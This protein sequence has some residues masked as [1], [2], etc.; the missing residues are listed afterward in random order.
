M[1]Q[2]ATA[3]YQETLAS[4]N[5][6]YAAATAFFV[7]HAGYS[8]DPNVETAEEGKARTAETLA[9]AEAWAVEFDVTFTWEPDWSVGDH[10]AEF[11]EAYT[12][13]PDTCEVCCAWWGGEVIASLGCIDDASDAYR[14]VIEAELAAEVSV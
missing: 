6:K 7:E 12:E 4:L 13:Q 5:T 10:V 8:Y 2:T 9:G 1:S 14:R 11:G 3:D